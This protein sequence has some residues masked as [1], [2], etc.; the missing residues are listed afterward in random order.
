MGEKTSEGEREQGGW[1]DVSVP[2]KA[3]M[4]HWPGVPPVEIEKIYDVEKGDTFSISTIKIDSHAGTHIDPPC[5]FI[6]GAVGLDKMPLDATVGPARVIEVES[7]KSVSAEELRPHGIGEGERVLFKTANSERCWRTDEF[8]ED[9]VY[10]SLEAAE[11]LAGLRVRAVGVDYLSVAAL[12]EFAAPTHIAL[13]GAGVWI[14]EGL[15]LSKVEAG[16]YEL[17]CL[18]LR[19]IEGDGSPARAILGPID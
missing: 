16:S 10:V 11:Y 4:V 2:V 12:D 3:N 13:L 15:D 19:I 1:I 17:I 14:I 7:R 8:L 9:Y 6:K 18:P 5:H